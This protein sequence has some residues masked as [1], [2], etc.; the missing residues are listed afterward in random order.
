MKKT[1][2]I[3]REKD[4]D[5]I[6]LIIILI[7]GIVLFVPI[8]SNDELWNFANAYKMFNGYGIYEELNVIITP[9]FFYIAQMF[10]KIFGS[11]ILAFRI[12]NIVI[13][14]TF[15]ILI[16]LI[17]KLLNVVKRRAFFYTIIII[18][19]FNGM[20]AAGANYNVLAMIPVLIS[21]ILAIKQKD[22][23][24]IYGILLFITFMIKQ[25]VY[26]FFAI[27]IFIYKLIN[28]KNIIKAFMELLKICFISL[29]GIAIFL[30]YMYLDNNI[31]NFINYCFLG[32]SEFGSQ[33]MHIS[34]DGARYIYISIIAIIFTII[35]MLNKKINKNIDSK[36]LENAKK[37]LSFGIPM[38]LI[39]YPLFN[40]YHSTL[41]SVIIFIEFIY[42]IENL[43]VKEIDIKV[44]KEKKLYI[45]ICIIYIIYLYSAIYFTM[46]RI[47]RE[48]YIFC[49]NG[50][51]YGS[52]ISKENYEDIQIICDYI[53]KQESKNIDVKILSYKANLYMLQL[54]KNN[55][56]FDLAFLGN[57]GK[58]GEE[59]LINK[60]KELDNSV[61]LI[62]TDIENMFWQ[63]S[64]N[65][66]N[67]IINNYKK[68][69]EIQEF[70]IYYID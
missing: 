8:Q 2:D 54:N 9:L 16:Y 1:I 25:N 12:Y 3:L 59:T 39:S 10:F 5:V 56:I 23:L 34:F 18:F 44:K 22:S 70:S 41:A 60:I 64:K 55:G 45:I 61:I 49:N 26:V 6:F 17:F 32:I 11:N 27:G 31:Y 48:E 24:W 63:E 52:I 47:N 20:V 13:S 67:Y 53:K 66:R 46:W 62:E 68:V 42:I 33:N 36:V 29:I 58:G 51:F 65:A 40:Y 43:L 7:M 69:G 30:I 19:M 35:L 4:L 14:S 28:E 38:L 21:I 37:I 57:Y 50:S 15:F